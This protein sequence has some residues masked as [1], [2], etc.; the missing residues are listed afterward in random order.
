M[1]ASGGLRSIAFILGVLVL[2][3]SSGQARELPRSWPGP[4]GEQPVVT[5]RLGPSTGAPDWF[6]TLARSSP[7]SRNGHAMAYD[8]AR[9]RVVLFGG[10]R[11]S[12]YLAD[13]WE[14]D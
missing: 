10:V 13:T 3:G 4:A 8:S 9:G 14:W 5:R 2:T 7:L 6:L 1:R 12:G 11:S